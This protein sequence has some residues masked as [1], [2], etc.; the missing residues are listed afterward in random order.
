MHGSGFTNHVSYGRG[1]NVH[2]FLLSQAHCVG[3]FSLL[4]TS[5]D[6]NDIYEVLDEASARGGSVPDSRW[7]V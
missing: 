3:E 1:M 6:E 4:C 7:E 2:Y 5:A